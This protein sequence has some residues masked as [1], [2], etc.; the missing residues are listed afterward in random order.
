MEFEATFL[1]FQSLDPSPPCL[2]WA[3]GELAWGFKLFSVLSGTGHWTGKTTKAWSG[4]VTSARGKLTSAVVGVSLSSSAGSGCRWRCGEGRSGGSFQGLLYGKASRRLCGPEAALRW[5]RGP[6]PRNYKQ[7]LPSNKS[8]LCSG[9]ALP[10]KLLKMRILL[11][12]ATF[13]KGQTI[14]RR[15]TC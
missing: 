1:R 9:P 11:P 14:I 8:T 4:G 13:S 5:C 6:L 15:E 7:I 10:P 2:A 12:T 3:L